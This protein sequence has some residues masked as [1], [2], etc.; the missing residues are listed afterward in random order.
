MKSKTRMWAEVW[1]RHPRCTG[2]GAKPYG[3]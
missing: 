2:W 1:R 3:R